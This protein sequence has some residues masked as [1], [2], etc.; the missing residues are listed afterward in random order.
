MKINSQNSISLLTRALLLTLSVAVAFHV[1]MA[2]VTAIVRQHIY[3]I[4]PIRLLG[5]DSLWAKYENS[6]IATAISWMGLIS[7]YSVFAI[8]YIR[9][10]D[11]E[12]IDRYILKLKDVRKYKNRDRKMFASYKIAK[13]KNDE[14][15]GWLVGQFYRLKDFL[16]EDRS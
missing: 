7:T 12:L 6:D 3:Y 14:T 8:L 13:D 4:N 1:T 10:R 2:I 9:K 15:R 5:V 16:V 11:K